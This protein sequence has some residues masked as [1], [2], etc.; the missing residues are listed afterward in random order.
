MTRAAVWRLL[1][2]LSDLLFP[3]LCPICEAETESEGLCGACWREARFFEGPELC[4]SC[5]VP[6]GDPVWPETRRLCLDCLKLPPPWARGRAAM[7]YRGAGRSLALALKRADRLEAAPLMARWMARAAGPLLEDCEAVVPASAHWRRTLRRRFDPAAEL[8]RALAR[9]GGKPYR[10]AWLKRLRATPSQ[11]GLTARER[12]AN[13]VDAFAVPERFRAEIEGRRLLIV[14]DVSTTGAT[15][16][17]AAQAM[18]AA[19]ARVDVLAFARVWDVEEDA[20]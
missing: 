19:G 12:R 1:T 20:E 18:I 2:P 4:D 13:L 8:A 15:L 14:D 11:G 7:A 6:A 3:H 16:G 5:G 17:A 9:L 10:P